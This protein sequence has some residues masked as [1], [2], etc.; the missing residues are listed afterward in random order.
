M[1]CADMTS[2]T[3]LTRFSRSDIRS[4]I[5]VRGKAPSVHCIVNQAAVQVTANVLLAIGAEPS[6]TDDPA[7]TE[8][9]LVSADALSV[10]LGMLS[11]QKRR[12]INAAARFAARNQIPWVLDPA[13][14]NRSK[15]RAH[16][17]HQLLHYE[18]TVL[19]ANQFEIDT[20][21]KLLNQSIES[22]S[23]HYGTIVVVTGKRNRIIFA[24]KSFEVSAG[25]PWMRQV[26]GMGCALSAMIAAYVCAGENSIAS[27]EEALEIYAFAGS[28]AAEHS[29][30]PGTFTASLLD[31]LFWL[32]GTA[33][34]PVKRT[35]HSDSEPN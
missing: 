21:C 2:S 29:S 26:T 19:R 16:F 25:H 15:P 32:H 34:E 7:E 27:I 13:L 3:N 9:F 6:M 18:P 33:P 4:E 14:I 1:Q 8:F 24:G 22:V 17:C 12:S 5:D 10:N 20:L 11:D 28:A 35:G 23:D 30:G 31:W